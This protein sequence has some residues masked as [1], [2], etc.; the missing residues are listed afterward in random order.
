MGNFAADKGEGYWLDLTFTN[1]RKVFSMLDIHRRRLLRSWRGNSAF[2]PRYSYCID[3]PILIRQN[4]GER[5]YD[6]LPFTVNFKAQ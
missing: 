6:N 3:G 4:V 1:A 5:Y 2:S